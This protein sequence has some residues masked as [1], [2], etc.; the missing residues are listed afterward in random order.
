[1]NRVDALNS[2]FA[3]FD[4]SAKTF[5][6]DTKGIFCQISSEYKGEEKPENL[7]RRYAKIYYNAF[8]IKFTYTAHGVLSVVNSIL[9]CSIS[10]DKSEEH[11][12][13]IPLP[14]FMDYCDVDVAAPMSIPLISNAEGMTQAFHCIGSV[15]NAHLEEI[16]A[17][18]YASEKHER[19]V[20]AFIE[21]MKYLLELEDSD[22]L[23]DFIDTPLEITNFFALRFASDAFLN[24]LKGNYPKAVNQ[25]SK[26]KKLTGY[27]K[28]MLRIWSSETLQIP[29]ISEITVNAKTYNASGVQKGSWKELLSLFLATALIAPLASAG[30]IL[31]YF[32]LVAVEGWQSVY[33]LGPIY[34]FP[35]C[36]V[37][38][39][40]TGFAASYFARFKM[41]QWICKKDYEKYCEM[42]YIQN[43]GGADRLMKGLLVL[44]ITA[45]LIVSVLLAKWNLNFRVD[46]FVDNTRFLSLKGQ[47]YAYEEI[48]RVYYK[49]S[50]VNDFNETLD[51]P[52]YVLVLKDGNEID[53]YE[54]GEISDYEEKLLNHLRA[55]GV[56]V[57]DK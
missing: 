33:L 39:F 16:T 2:I 3:R 34:N 55:S 19:I 18:S 9:S 8:V 56:T 7:I 48:A 5:C 46:G 21:E 52:S 49:A 36:I 27:E 22:N 11:V 40:V 51:Y 23:E 15:L 38:G 42:D 6:Q 20:T 30:Y 13:E 44:I 47:Y 29:D 32:L 45:G 37:A 35:F 24:S 41:Y 50:R 53:L 25:L 28:R 26:V 1:M 31:V 43:G 14:L 12:T 57:E 54:Y 17:I 10:F 4:L